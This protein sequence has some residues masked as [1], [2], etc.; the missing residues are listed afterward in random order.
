MVGW[1]LVGC[2]LVPLLRTAMDGSA[3]ERLFT[4]SQ[5]SSGG[6]TCQDITGE[7]G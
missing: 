2:K 5:T 7:L 3:G 1:V 4:T 6:T